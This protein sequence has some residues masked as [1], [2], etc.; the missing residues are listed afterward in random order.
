MRTRIMARIHLIR[1]S[2]PALYGD[3]GGVLDAGRLEALDCPVVLIAGMTSPVI[4]QVI[5][6]AL[7]ARL[8]NAESVLVPDAGHM[9]PVTH[10]ELTAA[11]IAGSVSRG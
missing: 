2:H 11:L 6:R 9:L 7:K 1:A 5:V 4:C 10:A 8:P 3:S